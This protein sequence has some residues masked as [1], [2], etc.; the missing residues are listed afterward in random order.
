MLRF[1]LLYLFLATAEGLFAQA[2]LTDQLVAYYPLDGNSKDL[3]DN[4][5]NGTVYGAEGTRG[6][7]GRSMTA[8]RFDGIDDYIEIPH[9]E[10]F[11]FGQEDDFAISF[12]YK[13]DEKQMDRDTI[14]NDIISKW[15][16]DDNSMKHLNSGYPFTFRVTNDKAKHRQLIAAQFGGYTYGCRDAT[17]IV[18]RTPDIGKFHHVVLN[19]ERG[20]FYLYVDGQLKK[21]KGTNVF[22]SSQNKAPLRLGKRGGLEFQNHFAGVMDELMIYSRA[23]SSEE[24]ESLSKKRPLNL[25]FDTAVSDL[26]RSDTLYFD[27][28][29]FQL[30]AKQRIDLEYFHRHLEIGREYH[31]VIEGHSNG[32]PDDKFCDELSLKRAKVIENYL[33]GLGVICTK[34]TSKGLGK[35]YQISP[36]STPVL[37]KKNQRA[38]IKLYR[39]ARA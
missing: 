14:D 9:S 25:G 20:R 37:R 19:V 5:L 21:R 32:L 33:L 2:V 6:I 29:I 11:N 34:I 17:T 1:L 23:L 13:E 8:M 30:N 28:D 39:R 10:L 36:N 38:E 31:L 22:C 18:T 24:I 26:L 7:N 12:W 15:V 3:S 27:D 35:R 16:T 4:C